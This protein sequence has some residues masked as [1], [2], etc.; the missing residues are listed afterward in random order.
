MSNTENKL[1]RTAGTGFKNYPAISQ[2]QTLSGRDQ[3]TLLSALCCWLNPKRRVC[4]AREAGVLLKKQES[5]SEDEGLRQSAVKIRK[6][7][8][9]IQRR[10]LSHREIRRYG[11]F[12]GKQFFGNRLD[13]S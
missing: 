10:C 4:E 7:S 5:V 8:E 2:L 13:R 12:L 11:L 3:T 6:E 1:I 9:E